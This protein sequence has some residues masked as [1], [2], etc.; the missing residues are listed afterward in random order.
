M[1]SK[2]SCKK[3]EEKAKPCR[4][5]AEGSRGKRLSAAGQK[6]ETTAV[7]SETAVR[8]DGRASGRKWS[9]SPHVE[10]QAP[11]TSSPQRLARRS[12]EITFSTK[13][14]KEITEKKA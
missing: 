6:E 9:P 8:R 11:A 10:A 14:G 2:T 13:A 1:K 4:D 3:K 12:L 7:G 5:R